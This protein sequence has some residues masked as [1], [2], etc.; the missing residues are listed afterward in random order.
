MGVCSTDCNVVRDVTYHACRE[1]RRR[2]RGKKVEGRSEGSGTVNRDN[3]IYSS[4][5]NSTNHDITNSIQSGS[6]QCI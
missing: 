3:S 5:R 2:G 1:W 6:V 4:L